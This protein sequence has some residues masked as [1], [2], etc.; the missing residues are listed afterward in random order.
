MATFEPDAEP[1]APRVLIADD[2]P[3]VRHVLRTTLESAGFEV[4]A[5][6]ATGRET[7]ERVLERQPDL[8]VLDLVMSDGDGIDV[9]R[10][11]RRS[12]VDTPIVVLTAGADDEQALLALSAGA[13]GFL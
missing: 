13:V 5:E 3:L 7:V 8:L 9:I 2:D 1:A 4:V 10:R 11:L 6:A 12:G